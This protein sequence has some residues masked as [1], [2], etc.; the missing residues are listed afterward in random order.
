MVIKTETVRPLG[1]ELSW[2]SCGYDDIGQRKEMLVHEIWK[3]FIEKRYAYI[4]ILYFKKYKTIDCCRRISDHKKILKNNNAPSIIKKCSKKSEEINIFSNGE[5]NIYAMEGAAEATLTTLCEACNLLH[6][7][8]NK[9]LVLLS[10]NQCFIP[11]ENW[12]K[13]FKKLDGVTSFDDG[14]LAELSRITEPDDTMMWTWGFFDD[15]E[16]GFSLLKKSN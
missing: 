8:Q 9:C 4:K 15:R 14:V 12:L 2:T 16:A 7:T 6:I 5:Q 3:D 13:I 1:T 10:N 11:V